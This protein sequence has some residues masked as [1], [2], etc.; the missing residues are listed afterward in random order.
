MSMGHESWTH[1]INPPC[2]GCE[3]LF[4]AL[5]ITGKNLHLRNRGPITEVETTDSTYA[6]WKRSKSAQGHATPDPFSHTMSSAQKLYSVTNFVQK[7][8]STE[9]TWNLFGDKCGWGFNLAEN[10][11]NT[12]NDADVGAQAQAHPS[13]PLLGPTE[14]GGE[15][16]W[17]TLGE[18][19]VLN[20]AN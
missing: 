5:Q 4:R 14:N 9:P 2:F 16:A 10:N 13:A 3:A 7:Y 12:N 15:A 20:R 6:C 17:G 19:H 18:G 8:I 11:T 1:H